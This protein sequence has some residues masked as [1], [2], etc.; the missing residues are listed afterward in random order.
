MI[1]LDALKARVLAADGDPEYLHCQLAVVLNEHLDAQPNGRPHAMTTVSALAQI[2]GEI[3]G[4]APDQFRAGAFNTAVQVM[5][6]RAGIAVRARDKDGNEVPT[7]ETE[8][9]RLN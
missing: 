8:P 1:D 3:V 2:I 6:E 5:A 7:L 4:H 9:G